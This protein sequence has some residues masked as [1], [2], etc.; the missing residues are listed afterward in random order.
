MYAIEQVAASGDSERF[1]NSAGASLH[2]I[3]ENVDAGLLIKTSKLE[4]LWDCLDIWEVKATS[5]LL[6]FNLM[7]N[8]LKQANRFSREDGLAYTEEMGPVY[9]T[10]DFTDEIKAKAVSGFSTMQYQEFIKS[11]PLFVFPQSVSM[12]EH[13]FFSTADKTQVDNQV[14]TTGLRPDR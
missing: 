12:Y 9:K 8:Y 3:D 1:K 7:A 14:A 13:K 5:Y 11:N 6:A 2:Y 10:K 4:K